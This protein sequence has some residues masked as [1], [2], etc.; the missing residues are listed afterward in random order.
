MSGR[1]IIKLS[2]LRQRFGLKPGADRDD[3][4]PVTTRSTRE[5]TWRPAMK[6]ALYAAALAPILSVATV[7]S[8]PVKLVDKLSYHHNPQR[9]GWNDREQVLTPEAVASDAFGLLWQ[10]PQLDSFNNI[11]PRLFATPLYLSSVRIT[12]GQYRGKTVS[13]VYAVTSTGYAYAISTEASGSVPPG[14]ILWKTRLTENPCGKG[15]S[16]NLSTPIIDVA[17]KRIY[18]TSCQAENDWQVH[19]LDIGSGAHLPNWPLPI[20]A[21]VIDGQGLNVNGTRKI[22]NKLL[23]QRGALALSPDGARL[24][25]SFGPYPGGWLIAIDTKQPRIG[26]A[27]SATAVDEEDQGGMWASGGPAIDS[28]GRI[29]IATGA[30]FLATMKKLGVPGVF[31]ESEGSWGQ[32]ILQFSDDRQTGLKLIGT[33]T[34]FNYCLSAASDLDLSSSGTILIDL[35]PAETSTPHLLALGGGKE[36]NFYLLDRDHMPGGTKRRQPCSTDPESDKS[37]LAPHPQRHF[38]LFLRGPVNLFGPHSDY[39]GVDNDAKSRSTAAYFR[40]ADGGNFVF[41]TG[42]TRAPSDYSQSVPPG[43]A[44]V[45]IVTEPGKPAWPQ[46]AALEMTQTFINPGSPIVTSNGGQSGI[47]W[48]LDVNVPRSA[49]LYDDT[50]PKP[51]LYALSTDDLKLLWRTAPGELF[52]TG[53]YNEPTVVNGLVLVG[54]DRIQAF[55]LRRGGAPR[56]SPPPPVTAAPARRAPAAAVSPATPSAAAPAL[57]ASIG[58]GGKLFQARCAACHGAGQPGSPSRDQL[59]SL[60]ASRIVETLTTGV[61]QPMAAGLSENDI[62]DIAQYLTN[63]R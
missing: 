14:T 5:S 41:V 11:P 61:M 19:A 56:Q 26:S 33:Y 46:I 2:T 35:P 17:K 38:G 21:E 57:A 15:E 4:R 36:G 45:K 12:G 16:G 23:R 43:L 24:Y 48:V 37:L 18:I 7:H 60:A 3:D 20:S 34:P 32:S 47:V 8:A 55:G 53:K 9:T 29:H 59:G 50:L 51:V 62:T 40:A 22:A 54:T 63:G 6:T 42:S 44:K 49:S 27:F 25:L 58:N 30:S 39:V 10:S 28:Q 31:P 52:S 1:S 13:A